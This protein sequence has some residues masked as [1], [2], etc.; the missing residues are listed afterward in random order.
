MFQLEKNQRIGVIPR[1]YSTEIVHSADEFYRLSQELRHL[2]A[3]RTSTCDPRF[4]FASVQQNIWTPLA[5]VVSCA[6]SR[7]G[8]VFAKERKV[9]GVPLGLIYGDA[10]L[11][12][13]VVAD[14]IDREF[15]LEAGLQALI[16][17]RG[18][19]G[20]RL[21]IPSAGIEDEVI[22]RFLDSRP[23]DV[24]RITF[25][26]HCVLELGP[27]YDV[28]LEKLS[29]KTRRNFRYYRR[30]FEALGWSYVENVPPAEFKGAAFNL[31]QKGVVGADRNGIN[32]AL[33][34]IATVEKPIMV[35]LRDQNGEWLSILGGWY[36]DDCG[37]VFL[38]MNNDR[39][40]PQSA[41]YLVLRAYLIETMI[42]AKIPNM[43]FWD[44]VG[45]PLR[46]YCRLPA[47]TYVYLDIPSFG[48]RTLRRLIGWTGRFLPAY[49]RNMANWV[50]HQGPS[51]ETTFV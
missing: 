40:Y 2:I 22:R 45:A 8:V 6:G 37:I 28:F 3:A 16:D 11:D 18:S 24:N 25:E 9:A 14:P 20:L 12:A 30:R 50:Q 39:D 19:R 41:L 29:K 34:M 15:V 38:Q 36:E 51:R 44:G 23:L 47:S 13:M 43:L 17:R 4:F 42:A 32:R 26:H 10:T 35:G 21:L 46:R 1:A 27:S 5:V 48:W 33:G 49:L 31:L 7:V